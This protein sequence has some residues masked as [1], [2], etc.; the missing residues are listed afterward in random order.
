MKKIFN[1]LWGISIVALSTISCTFAYTQEQQDAYQWAYKYGITT[2]PTIEDAK[3][4]SPLTRQAFAKMVVNYLENVVWIKQSTLNSCYF[5]D[6]NKITNDLKPYTKKVCA[7]EMEKILNLL[8]LLIEH[9]FELFSQEFYGEINIMLSENDII[10]T[11]L[12]L[13]KVLEL[14][15][16]LKML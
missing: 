3:M 12:M 5:P 6:E 4:N 11:M 13:F 14:W 8:I 1:I 10:S 2:K 15:T 9:S 16:I 7:Y